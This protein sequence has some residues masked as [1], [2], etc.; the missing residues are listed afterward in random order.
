MPF[1][2]F[3][4][5]PSTDFSTLPGGLQAQVY[6]SETRWIQ[7]LS[8]SVAGRSDFQFLCVQG[9]CDLV[10][11]LLWN[12]NKSVVAPLAQ[13]P[14]VLDSMVE[15]RDPTNAVSLNTVCQ[16]GGQEILDLVQSCV[17][18]VDL[19]VEAKEGPRA[20]GRQ[21]RRRL[22]EVRGELRSLQQ[23]CSGNSAIWQTVA[24][25]L[26]EFLAQS[27]QV[28]QEEWEHANSFLTA[29]DQFFAR[30]VAPGLHDP[31]INSAVIHHL[32]RHVLRRCMIQC[33]Q[34][35]FRGNPFRIPHE[36]EELPKAVCPLGT[37][38]PA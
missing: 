32:L 21:R 14:G 3:P 37:G 28:M 24:M 22:N 17:T 38:W 20:Q 15:A 23:R 13:L 12:D 35:S 4:A 36:T 26:P 2:V 6:H 27:E 33:V 5:F 30:E 10:Q 34:K 25:S 7:C 9:Q 31:A 16:A 1:I 8:N 11:P 29:R 18:C 19:L